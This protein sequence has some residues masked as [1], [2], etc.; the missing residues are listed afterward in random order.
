MQSMASERRSEACVKDVH[1]AH[2]EDV[3]YR[4]VT[5]QTVY[6]GRYV[7]LPKVGPRVGT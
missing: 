2:N 6:I 3:S 4:S 1:V 5:T 7:G